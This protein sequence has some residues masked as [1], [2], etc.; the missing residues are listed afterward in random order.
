MNFRLIVRG[1]L[2]VLAVI[3]MSGCGQQSSEPASS[4]TSSEETTEAAAE[5]MPTERGASVYEAAVASA[6]RPD[7]DRA[8]D[9]GRKPAAVLEFLGVERGMTVLD[10]FTGGGYYAEIIAGVV[11]EEGK[12]IAQSNQ[13]YLAFVGDAF[14][15]RFGSGRLTNVEVL[16]AENNELSLEAD[17]LDAVMMVLSFHDLYLSDPENGWPQIHGFNFLMELQK[18]LKPGGFVAIIDHYAEAGSP[19]EIGNTLHRIDPA[20]VVEYME[21]VGFVLDSQSDILRNPDDDLS[22]I[23]FGQV[24]LNTPNRIAALENRRRQDWLLGE[25][26]H[27]PHNLRGR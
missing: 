17:S 1:L 5:A 20:I 13:A 24:D 11:G 8:R 12:V 19:P 10:M 4:D 23:V 15:E 7:S 16:M 9:A 22:K 3:F 18:G 14:E 21:S 2:P 6:A 27:S 25:R 26:G